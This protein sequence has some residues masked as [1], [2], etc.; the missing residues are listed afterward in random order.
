VAS[1]V[2]IKFSPRLIQFTFYGLDL[3]RKPRS[4]SGWQS[5]ALL[6]K[7]AILPNPVV[8]DGLQILTAPTVHNFN[9]FLFELP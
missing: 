4:L 5:L 7:V 1:A 3:W 9:F 2:K 8:T 6:K